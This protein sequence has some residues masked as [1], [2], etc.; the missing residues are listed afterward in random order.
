MQDPTPLVR[1]RG[2]TKTFGGSVPST[3]SSYTIMPGEVHGLFGENGSGKS[4]LIK[5]LAGF[6][7]P[8]GGTLDGRR[9][10]R[11][12]CP[13]PRGNSGSWV[14]SSSTR[15][16]ASCRPSRSPRTSSSAR[17]PHSRK[18]AFLLVARRPAARSRDVRPL[19]R[20]HRPATRSWRRSGPSSAPCW[21]SCGRSRASATGRQ[22]AG[23]TSSCSTSRPCS[24]RSRRSACC[25]SFVRRITAT[26][27]SVLFVSHDLDEV[28]EITDRVTVLRDGRIGGTVVTAETRRRELVTMIIG[29]ELAEHQ[30]ASTGTAGPPRAWCSRCATCATGVALRRLVRPARRRGPRL[31]RADRLRLRGRRSTRCSAPIPAPAGTVTVGDRTI[32]VATMTPRRA[33]AP[34]HGTGAGRPQE[35][36][37]RRR[38]CRW[39]RT[40]TSG[41]RPVLPRLAAAARAADARTPPS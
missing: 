29:R 16:S 34:G 32:D 23:P 26:G 11:C 40:S 13:W 35:R 5:V 15:T 28:R 12:R 6:H 14:S 2:I 7:V 9:P 30:Q 31:R 22:A 10:G 17:S 36:G 25:S 20:R 33:M 3:T 38:R 1:A 18:A 27:S 24:C 41:A 21:P 39:P 8:D 19:R 4:T 37:Q